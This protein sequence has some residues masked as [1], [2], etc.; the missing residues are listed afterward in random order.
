MEYVNIQMTAN[1]YTHANNSIIIEAA[2]LINGT[3]VDTTPDTAFNRYS[4][5]YFPNAVF[6]SEQ[7]KT[8]EIVETSMFSV[9]VFVVAGGGLEPPTSGL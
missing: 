9:G 2:K 1:I 5:K 6:L 4:V 3:T 7:Q 8:T